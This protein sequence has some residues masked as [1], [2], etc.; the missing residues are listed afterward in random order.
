MFTSLPGEVSVTW[1]YNRETVRCACCRTF[2]TKV[3]TTSIE[4]PCE[5]DIAQTGSDSI[6]RRT[7]MYLTADPDRRTFGSAF[8]RTFR[9]CR[10][11]P[12]NRTQY[13]ARH[14][15]DQPSVRRLRTRQQSPMIHGE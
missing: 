6:L 5:N 13:C 3:F 15:I 9:L 12:W 10:R 4:L 2:L 1:M 7:T 8:L 11:S 14:R